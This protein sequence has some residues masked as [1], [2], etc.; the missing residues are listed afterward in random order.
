MSEKTLVFAVCLLLAASLA[1][2]VAG[3]RINNTIESM[4]VQVLVG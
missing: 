1:L 2:P 3:M 4:V